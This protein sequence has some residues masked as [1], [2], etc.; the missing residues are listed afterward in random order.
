MDIKKNIVGFI[1]LGVMGNAMAGHLLTAGYSMR[2]Y[3]RTRS[4]AEKLLE[5]GAVWVAD[6][7]T[8]AK[9]CDVIFTMVGYPS[10]VE[11]VYLGPHGLIANAK[12]GTILVDATTSS[13]ELALKIFSSARERNI[14]AFDAPVS[15]GDI[16]A[17]NAT[18]T[19]MVGGDAVIF[20]SVKPLLDLLGKTVILQGGAGA[21]QHTKMANQ[22]AVAG[23]LLGAIESLSYAEVAGL[24]PRRVLLSIGGG[25]AA[26]WQ[27]NNMVPRMLDGNFAPG[28]YSK[29]FR[30]D[31]SIALDAAK[32]MNT[33]LPLLEL[34]QSLFVQIEKSG[35][36]D[37]GTQI[38]Y[39][40]YQ[41]GLV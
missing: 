28:F 24:D 6:S 12:A 40:M 5:A 19:I 33:H 11:E 9:E 3:T 26:S 10:D 36:G 15:G 30:K 41:Q 18:L 27:L 13:P 34:A 38:L 7:K 17:K 25:S 39:R 21:G 8:L 32:A 4:K 20:D 22:I 1:G 14:H 16:G 31:L 23:N 35:L 29:H 2:V 37:A